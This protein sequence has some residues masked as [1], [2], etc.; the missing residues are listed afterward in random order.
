MEDGPGH[1]NVRRLIINESPV[2]PAYYEKM[3]KLLDTL[4]EQRRK[5]VVNYKEYLEKIAVLTK[6]ATTPGGARGGYP[7]SVNTAA[8]RALYNNVGKDEALALKVDA[9]VVGSRQDGW[10]G[11]TM[12]TRR[13]RN[14]IKAVLE[15]AFRDAQAAGFT[16]T[17]DG[18]TEYSI[19]AE[20]TRILEL[21]KHQNDY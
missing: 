8:K 16:G 1:A 5:G 18:A 20:A 7:A 15:Q 14:A 2:D 19:E 3:S 17:R 13:V 12:K 11:N 10:R 6:Q 9:A 4:I 21:V